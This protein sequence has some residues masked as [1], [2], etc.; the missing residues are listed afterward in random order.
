MFKSNCIKNLKTNPTAIYEADTKVEHLFLVA[1]RG[2]RF[3]YAPE[4]FE[5]DCCIHHEVGK[6]Y[7]RAPGYFFCQNFE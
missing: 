5:N 4:T 6:Q 3:R 1:R 2:L 7:P